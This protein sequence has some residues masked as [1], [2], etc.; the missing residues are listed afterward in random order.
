MKQ[1]RGQFFIL[2]AVIIVSLLAGIFFYANQTFLQ[3]SAGGVYSLKEEIAGETD[4]VIDYGVYN[5]ESHLEGFIQ[6]MSTSLISRTP[7]L[8]LV[9]FYSDG[10][11]LNIL[12]RGE[13][14]V[15][16]VDSTNQRHNVPGISREDRAEIGFGNTRVGVESP[17]LVS[18]TPVSLAVVGDNL[19]Y[20]IG[21]NTFS[22]KL[23]D[24]ENFYFV[25][26]KQIG[27]EL[28]VATND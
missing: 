1:K 9:F 26:R 6:N 19:E 18:I 25:I 4:R 7:D 20:T 15:T 13:S 22:S 21:E 5:G 23:L 27:E 12:N 17:V 16:F 14:N 28:Y 3:E 2:A 11:N 10:T 8:E 24:G